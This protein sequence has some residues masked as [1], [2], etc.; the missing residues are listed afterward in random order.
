MKTVYLAGLI[1]TTA[2]ES[3]QWRREAEIFLREASVVLSPMRGKENLFKET[4][5][6]GVTSNVL[7]N[8]DVII[9]DYNDIVHS[10]VILANLELFGSERPMI[11]TFCELAWAWEHHIPVVAVASVTNVLM[12][13]HPFVSSA[14]SHYCSDLD[15]AVDILLKHYLR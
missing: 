1:S 15:S 7:T 6:G 2:M 10:D 8:S 14:V 11:G 9:R 3:I 12:R 13:T 4:S 5:D